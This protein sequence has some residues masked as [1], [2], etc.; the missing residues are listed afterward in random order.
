MD[1]LVEFKIYVPNW[2]TRLKTDYNGSKRMSTTHKK[3]VSQKS[4]KIWCKGLVEVV[5]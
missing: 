3:V 5:V 2:F 4:T 1:G